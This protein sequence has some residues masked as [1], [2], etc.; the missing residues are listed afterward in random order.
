MGSNLSSRPRA[1]NCVF[2]TDII[3]TGVGISDSR[4]ELLFKPF[5]ELKYKHN[6]S[7]VKDMNIGMGL[8]SSKVIAHALGGD[9]IIKKSGD[10]ITCVSFKIPCKSQIVTS[11]H[12]HFL[13]IN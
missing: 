12:S 8:T 2:E 4:K 7:D 11:L 6:F 5:S 13:N 1:F 3:D 10:G 9:I